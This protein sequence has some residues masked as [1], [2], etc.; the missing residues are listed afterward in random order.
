MAITH[1]NSVFID[2]EN[3]GSSVGYYIHTGEYES[4]E[5][6]RYTAYGTVVLTDCNHKIDWSF[7]ANEGDI[8]KIDSAI[9]MLQDFRKKYAETS[10]VIAKLN[11]K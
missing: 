9:A 5:K 3:C 7:S 10:K 8:T 4:K 1:Q 11:S 6:T 2:P